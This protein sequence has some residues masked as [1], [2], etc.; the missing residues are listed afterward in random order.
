MR[1]LGHAKAYTMCNTN[2]CENL[3]KVNSFSLSHP[4]LRI[5]DGSLFHC[6]FL[7][8]VYMIHLVNGGA[9]LEIGYMDLHI[10]E[11]SHLLDA[12]SVFHPCLDIEL[13][14]T[15]TSIFVDCAH[16]CHARWKFHTHDKFAPYAWIDSHYA[17]LVA[18]ISM[19]SM[20]YELVHFLSKFVVIFLDGIF[21]HK[22]HIAFHQ[23]HDNIH[24]LSIHCHIRAIDEPSL[25]D[26]ILHNGRICRFVHHANYPM[27]ALHTILYH[28]D[29]LHVL[30]P[31]QSCRMNSY[32]LHGHFGCANHSISK[33]TLC[34]LILHV[35]HTGD[36]LE[37]L[38][39]AM[40][41]PT[42]H[43]KSVHDTRV[44]GDEDHDPRSDLSQ[45]GEMMWSILR[46]S[47]CTLRL[48]PKP[49][50]DIQ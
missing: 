33:C 48:L 37:Y 1:Q 38:D 35:L 10:E 8:V 44:H 9:T 20:I 11:R 50:E 3:L 17:C 47:P 21:I 24:I 30:C 18:S 14:Y 6:C 28:L 34:F 19:S 25:Y 32:L 22:D 49:Q 29:K 42:S 27:N 41:S 45:V 4:Q 7:L 13:W 2:I 26:I 43:Y 40:P 36:T 12:P 23:L 15:N 31:E 46:S 16:T 5:L 39:C